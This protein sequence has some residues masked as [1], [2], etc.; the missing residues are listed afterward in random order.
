MHQAFNKAV[1]GLNHMIQCWCQ[2]LAQ[3]VESKVGQTNKNQAIH[4]VIF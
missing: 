4:N 3:K 1:N 2:E